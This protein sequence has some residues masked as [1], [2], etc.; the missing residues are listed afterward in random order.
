MSKLI[1]ATLDISGQAAKASLPG[2]GNGNPQTS[3]GNYL[4]TIM[5][6]IMITAA[7]LVLLYLI[8]GGI[9]WITSSGDKGKTEAARNKMT[10]AVI[11]L[12]VLASTTAIFMVIQNLL[13]ICVLSFGRK[14]C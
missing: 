13:D 14:G 1:A 4:G 3:F 10:N 5:S 6:G 2:A 12:I 8:W 7:V 9:E 11:G